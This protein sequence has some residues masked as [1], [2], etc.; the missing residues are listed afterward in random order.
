[1][2]RTMKVNPRLCI[3]VCVWAASIVVALCDDEKPSDEAFS[4]STS[5]LSFQIPQSFNRS[6]DSRKYQQT[7]TGKAACRDR[8]WKHGSDFIVIRQMVIPDPAWDKTPEEMFADARNAMVG[9]GSIRIIAEH[10]Y[11]RDGCLAH[12][13]AVEFRKSN[14]LSFQRMDCFLT[15]PDLYV[16]VYMSPNEA[17]LQEAACQ[18]LF[19]SLSI[20]GRSHPTRT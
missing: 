16:V 7:E 6:G 1:M 20:R 9:S 2:T 14:T 15:K 13:F 3:V 8:I 5:D 4:R 18:T 11:E 19:K 10:D 12:S 17:A